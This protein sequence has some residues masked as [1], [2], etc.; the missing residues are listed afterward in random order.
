[1][2]GGIVRGGKKEE[3]DTK[4]D[5]NLSP[6]ICTEIP[7]LTPEEKL[8]LTAKPTDRKKESAI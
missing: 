1:M 4:R 6:K 2:E 3:E 7:K 5:R 8:I